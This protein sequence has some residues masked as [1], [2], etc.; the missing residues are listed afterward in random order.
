VI[1]GLT[2]VY[3]MAIAFTSRSR[4]PTGAVTAL[5][6]VTHTTPTQLE[7]ARRAVSASETIHLAESK[8]WIFYY[9]AL[10]RI[11][12]STVLV[13]VVLLG[14][15]Y[16]MPTLPLHL[17]IGLVV[18]ALS[19]GTLRGI[20]ARVFWE[21][22]CFVVTANQ[23]FICVSYPPEFF[24]LSSTVASIHLGDVTSSGTR[25]PGWASAFTPRFG[26]VEL[27]TPA[28]EDRAFHRLHGLPDPET[29]KKVID[30][31]RHK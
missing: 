21:S 20:K 5:G 24:T 18:I 27:E 30:G 25:T 10:A 13:A 3:W 6:V 2:F 7:R 17:L 8:H 31:A 4:R 14:A 23:A 16:L 28:Q 22:W 29:I 9:L 19:I 11:I 12:A 15:W 26:D 1:I